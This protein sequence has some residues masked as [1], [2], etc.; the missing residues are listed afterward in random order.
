MA[1]I[2]S[3]VKRP[4]FCP[5]SQ[6]PR[7]GPSTACLRCRETPARKSRYFR[8]SNRKLHRHTRQI[9]AMSPLAPLPAPKKDNAE[10]PRR[11]NSPPNCAFY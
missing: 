9:C 1:C 2:A 3:R 10:G 11:G 8:T 6:L 5:N 4:E 7:R